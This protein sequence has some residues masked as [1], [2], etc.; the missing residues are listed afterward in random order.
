MAQSGQ[1]GFF[2]L[3]GGGGRGEAGGRRDNQL[4]QVQHRRLWVQSWTPHCS[5]T[6]PPCLHP[7]KK[8]FV[9]TYV[10][11]AQTVA[12]LSNLF[13]IH[14]KR[15]KTKKAE[16]KQLGKSLFVFISSGHLHLKM[17]KYTLSDMC[18]VKRTNQ[19]I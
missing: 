4:M 19:P 12:H 15:R 17:T 1:G 14:R 7:K 18:L 13:L 10:V 8:C 16:E 9:L 6:S 5:E 2:I 3:V 11:L